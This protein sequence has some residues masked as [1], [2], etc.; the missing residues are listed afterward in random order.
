MPQST[1]SP[2]PLP[3]LL[4]SRPSSTDKWPAPSGASLPNG[5]RP[6]YRLQQLQTANRS[7]WPDKHHSCTSSECDTLLQHTANQIYPLRERP[8]FPNVKAVF[9]K[10]ICRFFIS[11]GVCQIRISVCSSRENFKENALSLARALIYFI[12]HLAGVPIIATFKVNFSLNILE[13]LQY[14]CAKLL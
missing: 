12:R 13:K 9:C 10:V 14:F 2:H 8:K 11:F 5:D 7:D 6:C 3:D 1:D 4:R